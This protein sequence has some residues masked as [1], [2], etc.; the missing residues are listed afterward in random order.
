MLSEEAS[1]TL[2]PSE[3]APQLRTDPIVVGVDHD[4]REREGACRAD[5]GQEKGAGNADPRQLER[6]RVPGAQRVGAKHLRRL[7]VDRIDTQQCA[8]HQED[9]EARQHHRDHRGDR[10]VHEVERL[11]DQADPHQEPVHDALRR[12]RVEQRV[13]R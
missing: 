13:G 4:H 12:E 2:L 10:L 7:F 5:E 1:G 11:V 8:A 3:Q 9:R 6:R